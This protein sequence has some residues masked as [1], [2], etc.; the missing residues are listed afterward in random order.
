MQLCDQKSAS[1][2]NY[3]CIY[4]TGTDEKALDNCLGTVPSKNLLAHSCRTYAK[5]Y[6]V[7]I[8]SSTWH[9]WHTYCA[10]RAYWN[11]RAVPL[12]QHRKGAH[13]A[14]DAAPWH[15]GGCTANSTYCATR[16]EPFESSPIS[17]GRHTRHWRKYGTSIST[18]SL[19]RWAQPQ[20]QVIDAAAMRLDEPLAQFKAGTSVHDCWNGKCYGARIAQSF[21]LHGM[22]SPPHSMPPKRV[23]NA[24][25]RTRLG[26]YVWEE[27][28]TGFVRVHHS[29]LTLSVNEI[30]E[31][32]VWVFY[33]TYVIRPPYIIT[34]P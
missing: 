6:Y 33:F 26:E 3:F 21:R 22:S 32:G 5:Y 28:G 29:L 13:I 17:C 11:H 4:F 23:R 27:C 10:M 24:L 34:R 30:R 16:S 18:A 25:P 2:T 12:Q 15:W 14:L 20:H 9:C 19:W 31:V 8:Y 1:S 7:K